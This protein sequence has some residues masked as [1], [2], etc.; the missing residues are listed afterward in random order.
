MRGLGGL[1]SCRLRSSMLAGSCEVL[2]LRSCRAMW[3]GLRGVCESW[4]TAS[5]EH[6]SLSSNGDQLGAESKETSRVQAGQKNR[7]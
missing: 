2:P 5:L 1:L 3:K 7:Q 4:Y 6:E